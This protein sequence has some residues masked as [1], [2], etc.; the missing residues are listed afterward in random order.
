MGPK[1]KKLTKKQEQELL[2]KKKQEEK[3]EKLRLIERQK[4]EEERRKKIEAKNLKIID[5]I[6]EYKLE[7]E[8]LDKESKELENEFL[9]R[10][11]KMKNHFL[12]CNNEQ[13]WKSY[14]DCEVGYLNIRKEKEITGFIY[15]FEERMANSLYV[16]CNF[17]D[18]NI[19]EEFDYFA[20]AMKYQKN[21]QKLFYEGLASDD[22]KKETYSIKYMSIL[23]ELIRNKVEYLTVYFLENFEILSDKHRNPSKYNLGQN[24]VE[25]TTNNFSDMCIEWNSNK[26]KVMRIGFWCNN[27][28]TSREAT[29]ANFKN[30]PCKIQYLPSQIVSN[31]AIVRFVYTEIDERD[32]IRS[33]Y[34]PY[35]SLNGMF[36]LDII[37]YPPKVITHKTWEMKETIGDSSTYIQPL[38]KETFGQQIRM[39][40]TINLDKKIFL[41]DLDEGKSLIFGRYNEDS[42]QWIIVKDN[43]VI[44]D[45]EQRTATFKDYSEIN[46]F[47]LLLDKKYIYPYKSWYLRTVLNQREVIDF[48]TKK[49]EL[50]T[51]YIGKLDI[52]SKSKK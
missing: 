5:D 11:N 24:S 40:V 17:I 47:T 42:Q 15:E 14:S 48:N 46:T 19:N 39:T 41:K 52:E 50:R 44:L 18:K 27:V 34:L 51:V 3:E 23:H 32:L 13:D 4:Q 36:K 29:I 45:K 1:P 28:A 33:S 35:I 25:K 22:I 37:S 38:I 21:F 26:S 9:E 20:F 12:L 8:R 30:I 31:T 10:Q 7:Q 2:E 49:K 6:K 43:T 16:N